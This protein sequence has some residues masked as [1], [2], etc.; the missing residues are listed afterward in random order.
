MSAREL[1]NF[2]TD[3]SIGPENI[4]SY[5]EAV[6]KAIAERLSKEQTREE[7]IEEKVWRDSF[8]PRTLA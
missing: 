4:D 7:E 5:L 1:F 3:T 2:V 8:I 6:Q